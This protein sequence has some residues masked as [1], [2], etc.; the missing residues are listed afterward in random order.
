MDG[1]LAIDNGLREVERDLCL[2]F[3]FGSIAGCEAS[4]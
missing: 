2:G 4:C 3:G 1:G